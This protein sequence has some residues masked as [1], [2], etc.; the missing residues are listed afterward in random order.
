MCF[1][2][3][4][5]ACRPRRTGIGVLGFGRAAFCCFLA[6]WHWE[7]NLRFLSIALRTE[8]EAMARHVDDARGPEW[9]RNSLKT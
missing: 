9:T 8:D 4:V 3:V 7:K 2:V 1:V 5:V 6:C